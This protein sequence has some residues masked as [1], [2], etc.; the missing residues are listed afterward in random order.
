MSPSDRLKSAK[1]KMERWMANGVHLGWLIDGDHETVYVYRKGGAPVTRRGIHELAG[2][3]PVKGFV[4]KLDSI[5]RGL[6]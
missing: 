1:E 3:G 2:E 5:W 4:L 6:R